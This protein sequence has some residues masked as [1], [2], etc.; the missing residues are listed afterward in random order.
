MLVIIT[1]AALEG[2]RLVTVMV[3]LKLL[4]A[5]AELGDASKEIS[6]SEF[7]VTVIGTLALLLAEVG[8]N[9]VELTEAVF[10]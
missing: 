9:V 10:V 3:K 2:P 1:F 5:G 4:D 7:G 8:S 6:K